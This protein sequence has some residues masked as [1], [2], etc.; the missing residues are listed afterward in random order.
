MLDFI[1]QFFEVIFYLLI[2]LGIFALAYFSTR[3]IAK[4]SIDLQK[5]KNIKVI[6]K[7]SLGKEKEAAI[8]RVGNEY[9][10]AGISSGNVNFSGPLS[11]EI[12]DSFVF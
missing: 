8:I 7:I 11:K 6:E 1:K 9:F 2:T 12:K 4:R 3:F 5:N 10:L